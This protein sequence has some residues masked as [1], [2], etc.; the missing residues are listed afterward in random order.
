VSIYK[1]PVHFWAL[2]A[3]LSPSDTVYLLAD[4]IEQ[5]LKEDTN[6]E[7]SVQS[8]F[9]TFEATSL[10]CQDYVTAAYRTLIIRDRVRFNSKH[11][12]I[13]YKPVK[14]RTI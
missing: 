5:V 13:Q 9:T 6:T 10:Q 7:Y 14:E 4:W 2:A 3:T 1:H 8:L 12:K 11:H